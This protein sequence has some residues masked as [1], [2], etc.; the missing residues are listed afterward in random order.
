[1]ESIAL[2]GRCLILLSLDEPLHGYGI[3]Q[4][5]ERLSNGRACLA[6]GTCTARSARCRNSAGSSQRPARVGERK[7]NLPVGGAPAAMRCGSRA[8]PAARSW[9]GKQQGRSWGGWFRRE[10]GHAPAVFWAWD[11]DREEDWLNAWAARGGRIVD[12]CRFR[13]I[14]RE[15]A[16]GTSTV[17][18]CWSMRRATPP[19][20]CYLDFLRDLDIRCI[21]SYG[22]WTYL[23]RHAMARQLDLFSDIDS[24]IAHLR[25]I[26]VL[27][28]TLL[29]SR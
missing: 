24:K 6:A 11:F 28:L 27:V 12:V 2:T 23:R 5:A 10:A 21:G 25:R 20:H 8:R 15:R 14:V 26:E 22:R 1:M 3:M 29:L 13:Y 7:K 17:W 18:S 4:N 19:S 16:G 9:V